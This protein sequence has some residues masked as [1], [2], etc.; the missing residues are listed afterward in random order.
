MHSL[1][2]IQLTSFPPHYLRLVVTDADFAYA[3]ISVK[4]VPD[5]MYQSLVM[6]DIRCLDVEKIC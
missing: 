3:L 1:L 2:Y 4:I 6:E 5:S